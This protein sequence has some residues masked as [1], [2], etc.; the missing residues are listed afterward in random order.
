MTKLDDDRKKL[1]RLLVDAGLS[2]HARAVRSASK[3][4]LELVPKR[5]R[6]V[7]PFA[8]SRFGGAPDFP[9]GDDEWPEGMTFL[10]EIN[11]AEVAAL[12]HDL[13][14][15]KGGL[16]SFFVLDGEDDDGEYLGTGYVQLD[17]KIPKSGVWRVGQP[18]KIEVKPCFGIDFVARLTIPCPGT[19]AARALRLRGDDAV[20][21]DDEV[22][23]AMGQPE[24]ALLGHTSSDL[25]DEPSHTRLLTLASSKTLG[26][27]WGDDNRLDFRITRSN[28]ARGR[29]GEAF[30]K[31][32]DA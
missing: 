5:V 15:P 27:R 20:A 8:A 23:A 29:L 6:G 4:A 13:D 11:L 26:F 30:S 21:Y 22:F 24:H 1:D 12:G 28:L 2:K 10:A 19:S 32:V 17:T 3:I 18:K 25:D 31:Y 9:A 14:L 7:L 16:L